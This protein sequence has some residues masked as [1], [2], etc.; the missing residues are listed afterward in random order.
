MNAQYFSALIIPVVVCSI[1][2]WGI[3][4]KVNVYD[5]FLAGVKDGVKLSF[6]LFPHILAMLSVIWALRASG[7]LQWMIEPLIPLAAW[8]GIPA[9]VLPLA[10]LRS[11]TGSGSLAYATE[12]MKTSGVDSL[13]GNIAA[14]VQ[15]SA[16]T[17][18]YV[19]TVYFGAV[20]VR[21]SGYALGLGLFADAIGFLSAIA[22]C[23]WW[24]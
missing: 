15:G 21:N 9:D 1:F 23:L 22:V 12:I 2:L 17:T 3:L 4:K 19:I 20:G 8:F 11:L 14:I 18:I 6:E 10:I 16:E 7:A 24:S 13:S 5:L